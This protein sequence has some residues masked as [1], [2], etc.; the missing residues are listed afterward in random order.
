M[1]TTSKLYETIKDFPEPVLAEIL[2][3]AEFL[4]DKRISARGLA[5]DEPLSKLAG[6][7]E[8]SRNFAEDPLA[9]QI[10]MRDEWN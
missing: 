7:L 1:S 10:R 6:G 2:D 9:L 5:S 8:N 4:R 3:F